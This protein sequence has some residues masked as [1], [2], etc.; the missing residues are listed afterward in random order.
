MSDVYGRS[1]HAQGASYTAGEIKAL[2]GPIFGLDPADDWG[3]IVMIET[4]G[5]D[6]DD[7]MGY[8]ATNYTSSEGVIEHLQD[9][10]DSARLAYEEEE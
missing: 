3:Y 5:T 7:G 6:G 4:P 10:I 2:I 1:H 8:V 9:T